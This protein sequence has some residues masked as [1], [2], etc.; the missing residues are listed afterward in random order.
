MRIDAVPGLS[1]GISIKAEEDLLEY[2]D[3]E[4]DSDDQSNAK[5]A[6]SYVQCVSGAQ[7]AI[8]VVFGEGFRYSKESIEISVYLD[9]TY[10]HGIVCGP[11][12]LW[13]AKTERISSVPRRLKHG[14]WVRESFTFA[15]LATSTSQP[16]SVHKIKTDLRQMTNLSKQ[17]SPGVT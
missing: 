16:P 2:C 11:K 9:G 6:E 10:V 5:S 15:D 12:S 4:D 7:F 3:A 8:N 13:T 14:Q 17:A 1:V